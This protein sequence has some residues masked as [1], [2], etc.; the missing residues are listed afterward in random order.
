MARSVRIDDLFRLILPGTPVLSPD[1]TRVAFV[2]KRLDRAE[3]RYRS[4]LWMMPAK[5]GRAR[6]L[7]NGLVLDSSPAWSPDGR[8]LAFVSDRGGVTNVWTLSLDGGEPEQVTK[9]RGGAI[10]GLGWSPSGKELLFSFFSI[11]KVDDK[12]RAKKATFKHIRDLYHKEDGFGWFGEEHWT[13]WKANV[14][15]G[16]AVALTKGPHHDHQP[17]WSP[18]GKWIAFVSQRGKN[19]TTTPDLASVMVMD[20]RGRRLRDL[21]PQGGS[22]D[23]PRWSLDGKSIYWVG[24]RGGSGEWLYHE[25]PVQK[26]NVATGKTVAL[27]PGHDRWVMNM[28]GSDT[29]S[30]GNTFAVYEHDGEERVLFGSDEDGSY[31]LYS[32][33]G[34]GG[35]VRLEVGGK[36]SVLGSSVRGNRCVYCASTTHD[37]GELYSVTLDGDA[38]AAP[39]PL[40]KLTAPFFRP[41]KFHEPEEFTVRSGK[42]DIQAWVLKPPSF[43][44]DRRYPCLIEVHG[45]PMTQYGETFFLEMQLLAAQGYV[46]A[47]CNPRG[48]SGRG[49]KFCNVIEG[50]WGKDDWAD[51]QALTDAMARKRYVDAK[52]IGILGGSYG[53]YMTSW[54]VGH[55]NRYKAAVTQRT[56]ADFWVHWGSSDFGYFRQHYFHGKQP[57]EA[58]LEYHKASPSFYAKNMKT[59][60]LIIHSEGDLRC[61]IAESEGLFTAMKVLDQAPCEMVRF[62]GE[63]HGLSRGGK[64][65]NREERLRRILDWF[66]RYL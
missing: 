27:N 49:M 14:R 17:R 9:L 3:N 30:A 31:R 51:V 24:Y 45:G 29:T 23:M 38:D 46:V 2:V 56:A 53:G 34:K 39:K 47:Y 66:R 12:E 28:V 8:S 54:A 19:A 20:A 15:S 37:T 40:T 16:R 65:A 6:A 21:T 5:G 50:K 42:V 35:G 55:T 1:G 63:F 22:R 61:P 41:L 52:R 64:P 25:Y 13:I 4:H 36:L 11:P 44:A 62:E 7:T 43:R 26:T 18:D 60:L 10:S 59:P 57:W 32:V 58:P 48:S 33:S